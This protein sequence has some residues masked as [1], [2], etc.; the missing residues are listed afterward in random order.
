MNRAKPRHNYVRP[1]VYACAG[2]FA[3]DLLVPHWHDRAGQPVAFLA[4]SLM[5]T[6]PFLA[7]LPAIAP[8]LRA[9]LVI[10][11]GMIIFSGAL[12]IYFLFVHDDTR[13]VRR[14]LQTG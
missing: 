7:S 2:Y 8:A 5:L 12:V 14:N 6:G 9:S 13:I 1:N 3:I 11:L 10:Y 4:Y